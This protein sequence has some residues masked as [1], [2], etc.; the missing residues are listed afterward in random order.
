MSNLI[1][2]QLDKTQFT[3]GETITGKAGWE[4]DDRPRSAAIR[5]FWKT[6]GRGTEDV[7]VVEEI[8]VP[9]PNQRQLFDFSFQLPVE[10]YS[11]NGRLISLA[12]GVEAIVGK[13]SEMFEF[14]MAPDGEAC[15]LAQFDEEAVDEVQA[16]R[17]ACS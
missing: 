1:R 13:Q 14:V 6:S 11:F 16:V 4:M 3:P 17:H 8:S 12:W 15:D 7:E 2:V 10:P 5:L 9:D